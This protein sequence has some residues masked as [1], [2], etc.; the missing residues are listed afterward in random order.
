LP[1]IDEL[2]S[3]GLLSAEPPEELV[4][5]AEQQAA[6]SRGEKP[7]ADDDEDQP[8]FDPDAQVEAA[9][10]GDPGEV[11]Q[12]ISGQGEPKAATPDEPS[13]PQFT[14]PAST[15][16]DDEATGDAFQPTT[17]VEPSFGA[18]PVAAKGPDRV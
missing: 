12:S 16:E 4:R 13:K 8:E 9:E 3:A 18:L 2:K 10:D 5:D 11:A 6:A 7:Q 15:A 1:G 17:S 14:A